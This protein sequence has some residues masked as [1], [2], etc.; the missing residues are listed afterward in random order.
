MK[1]SAYMHAYRLHLSSEIHRFRATGN[2]AV[3]EWIQWGHLPQSIVMSEYSRR[4][5]FPL[6]SFVV[7]NIVKNVRYDMIKKFN[8]DSKAEYSA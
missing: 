2:K 1:F 5:G 3:R 4:A 7:D 8:V 6:L